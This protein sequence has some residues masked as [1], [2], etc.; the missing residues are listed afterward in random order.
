L[1]GK[2]T[3]GKTIGTLILHIQKPNPDF[4]I[5]SKINW[6]AVLALQCKIGVVTI[7]PLLQGKTIKGKIIK[8]TKAEN[9]EK[10]SK[11]L[12]SQRIDEPNCKKLFRWV[13]LSVGKTVF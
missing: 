11:S 5:V 1:K 12:G 6:V 8:D 7:Q 4:P 13:H 2:T 9:V 3:K 10:N